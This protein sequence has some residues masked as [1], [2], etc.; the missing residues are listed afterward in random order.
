M[1]R[2]FTNLRIPAGGSETRPAT[3]LAVDGRIQEI[4]SPAAEPAE[5]D[6]ES[7]DLGG[8]L[9]LPGAIDGHV[10][11]DDPGFTHRETF[12]TGSR[13][14]AA[15]GVTCVVDMPCTS[16]P[17]VTSLHNLQAKLAVIEA[18]AHVDYMLWGGLSHNALASPEWRRDLAEI[19]AAGVAAIKVYM[20]SGMDSFRDLSRPQ[21]RDAVEEVARHGVPVGVHAEDR[22]MVREL[23]GRLR[24]EGR[25]EPADYAASRPAA[26]EIA[27]VETMREICRETGARVHI[28]HVASGGALDIVSAARDEGLPMSAETCPHFLQFT[29]SDFREQGALLKTAPVVKDPADRERLWKGLASGELLFVAT[30]HAAG[31]WPEEKRTGSIWTDY[32]GVPGVELSLPYLLS[33]GVGRGRITLERLTEVTASE[34]ARFFGLEHRKG[35][36]A[37]GLDADLAVLEPDERWTVRAEGL[38]NLNRYTPLEGYELKGR[39]CQTYVRAE[40]VYSRSSDGSERFGK[41]GFGGRIERESRTTS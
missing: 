25:D 6:V 7:L 27:A 34:P 41:P 18:K 23:T 14:A 20:L 8:R 30:D 13:A 28:V 38:H 17:P 32:G 5:E 35:R 1:R 37:P 40:P 33:E 24:A 2:R 31:Q 22:E 12:E 19:V 4:T 9:V 26:A 21:L 10:H 16:L 36:L 39:I 3:I 29:L 11:F 15:G